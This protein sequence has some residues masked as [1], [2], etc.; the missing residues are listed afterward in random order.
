MKNL[1]YSINAFLLAGVI[2]LTSCGYAAPIVE[3]SLTKED[4]IETSIGNKHY[5]EKVRKTKI[6]RESEI[7]TETETEIKQVETNMKENFE[8][9]AD[10]LAQ[11][12]KS[13]AEIS[14]DEKRKL[15]NELAQELKPYCDLHYYNYCS[16]LSL[17]FTTSNKNSETAEEVSEELYSKIN[18]LLNRTDRINL[19]I[20]SKNIN[21][22]LSKLNVSNIDVVNVDFYEN[23]P[24]DLTPLISLMQQVASNDKESICD[25]RLSDLNCQKI[26]EQLSENELEISNLDLFTS[27]NLEIPQLKDLNVKEITLFFDDVEQANINLA[28]NDNTGLLAISLDDKNLIKLGN[29][30]ITCDNP[31]NR[32]GIYL[33]HVLITENTKFSIDSNNYHIYL[34]GDYTDISPFYDISDAKYFDF[35]L[36]KNGVFESLGTYNFDDA[37]TVLE[38]YKEKSKVLK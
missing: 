28:L 12:L 25:I 27:K 2:T 7:E 16:T 13:Q 3:T 9:A 22:D 11:E 1:K 30:N 15:A 26:I 29:F 20:N 17:N 23:I 6:V 34:T 21:L 24:E 4:N 38:N 32:L 18:L 14:W 19:S 5:S 31:N 33:D 10:E 35:I 37:I 8:L 36:Y